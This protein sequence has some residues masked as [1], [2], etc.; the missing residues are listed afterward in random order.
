[1]TV[2]ILS[3]LSLVET[4]VPRTHT[5]RTNAAIGCVAHVYDGCLLYCIVWDGMEW[6]A[7]LFLRV[8][9]VEFDTIAREWRCK[10]SDDDDRLSLREAQRALVAVADDVKGNVVGCKSVM[11]V[12]CGGNKD[13]KVRTHITMTETGMLHFGA[14][15]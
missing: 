13:F 1:M 6:N 9:G 7:L 3:L 14:T 8:P 2:A 5:T 11:R 12:V 4:H 15:V 10:W